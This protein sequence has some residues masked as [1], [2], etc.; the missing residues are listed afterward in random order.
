VKLEAVPD[1]LKSIDRW[2]AWRKVP[3]P[4]GGFDKVPIGAEWQRASVTLDW[5]LRR[6]AMVK[7]GGGIGFV[8]SDDDDI[9]GVDLDCCRDPESGAL[10]DWAN[11]V[12][13]AFG[14]TYAEVSPS[15]TGVKLWAHGC[16]F[17]GKRKAIMPGN[18]TGGHQ[19]PLLEAFGGRGFFTVTGNILP[20]SVRRLATAD[21]AAAG[22][23][24]VDELLRPGDEPPDEHGQARA[25]PAGLLTAADLALVL[26]ALDVR[27][28]RENGW[29]GLLCACHHVCG[30][31]LDA[32]EVFAEWSRGDPA[33]DNAREAKDTRR[34]WRSFGAR[35][36][37]RVI[38][39]GTL[40]MRLHEEAT[41]EAGTMAAALRLKALTHEDE[42]DADWQRE[43]DRLALTDAVVEGMRQ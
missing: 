26:V 21:Q 15:A 5:A 4:A 37:V 18:P 2:L 8:F 28:F 43:P 24:L 16:P 1:E 11:A 31:N 22:W 38:G 14:S 41:D 32:M 40:L 30:G 33:F 42:T 9:G 6:L 35:Q 19:H 7:D 3:K 20:G 17:V 10:T 12:L 23:A 36:P 13:S 27:R 34:R 29:I 39:L 25:G